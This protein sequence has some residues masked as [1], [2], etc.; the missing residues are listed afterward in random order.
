[1]LARGID[2]HADR[3]RQDYRQIHAGQAKALAIDGHAGNR[4]ASRSARQV[5]LVKLREYPVD[6][7]L[8]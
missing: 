3:G 7:L 6:F 4:D 5:A 2:P 1:M 8:V